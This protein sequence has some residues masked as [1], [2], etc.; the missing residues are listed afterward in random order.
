MHPQETSRREILARLCLMGEGEKGLDLLAFASKEDEAGKE[1][2]GRVRR[3]SHLRPV[4]VLEEIH[5]GWILEKL[6]GE[7]PRLLGLVCRFVT[8]E[9]AQYL[10]SHLAPE[11]RKRLPKVRESYD[12]SPQLVEI[13]RE[14]VE[15]SLAVSLPQRAG[16]AFGFSHIAWMRDDDLRTFFRDLGL[17][18]IRK[19]FAEV[20][21]QIFRAFLARFSPAEAKEIRGRIET[22]KAVSLEEKRAA[23]KHLVSLSLENGE[24]PP[25]ALFREIGY[26]VFARALSPDDRDWA[27]WICQ[28]L[29]PEDGYRLKRMVQERTASQPETTLQERKEKILHRLSLLAQKGLIRRYWKEENEAK[30][31]GR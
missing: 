3:L 26:S 5:P 19:A 18:E 29:A 8:G 23:Q 12:L 27:E 31:P 25:D 24:L 1:Q 28:K 9:K 21:P 16:E 20:E 14:L 4:S 13:V 6:R 11:E 22:G 15:K 10:I 30:K 7:S 2:L 17:E